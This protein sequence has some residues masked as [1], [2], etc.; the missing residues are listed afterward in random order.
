M[1][2]LL[3]ERVHDLAVVV[4]SAENPSDEEWAQ[5]AR[6]LHEIQ[7]SASPVKGLLVTTLGGAPNAIQRKAVLDAVGANQAATSVCTDSLIARGVL[8]ALRWLHREPMHAF[9][10]DEVTRAIEALPVSRERLGDA[11]AVVVRLQTQLQK[12]AARR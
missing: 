8:T 3:F 5:Y 10:L 11:C 9:R 2:T 1:K 4:H 12:P 6:F 7:S